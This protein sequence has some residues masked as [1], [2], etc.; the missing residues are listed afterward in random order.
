MTAALAATEAWWEPGTRHAYHTNTYGHL[1][2]EVVRRVSGESCRQRL[3]GAGGAARRRRPRRRPARRSATAAPRWSSTR[4]PSLAASTDFDASTATTDGDAQ[5]LQPAG[6]LLHGRRQHGRVARRRGA[7][8]ERAR[9][10]A[11]AWRA[12]TPRCSNRAAALRR[13][14]GRGDGAAVRGLLPDPPRGGD[15]RARFKPTVPRRPFGPNPRSFGHFGTGGA[16]G[17]ADPDGGVAFG[18]VMNDVIPRWQSTRNR[19]LIDAVFGRS[20]PVPPFEE[21]VAEGAARPGRGLGLLLV[22]GPGHR[23]AAAVGLRP[24]AWG[25]A[26]PAPPR[27]STSRRAAARSSP[28]GAQP[29]ALLVATE[30]WPPNVAVARGRCAPLGAHVVAVAD[31]PDV[32]VRCRVVRP[33]GQPPPRRR[34]VGARSPG[35][36]GPAGPIC[37]SRS[38]R[39]P[40][41][42]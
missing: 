36:C 21:L 22:R 33:G 25:S 41:A 40:T 35:S 20:E 16:V 30:S 39:G 6:L 38:A 7:V 34:A 10:G 3:A 28:P 12:C 26:W 19:A 5:L 17:F 1:I 2:G 11:R 9:H 15:V 37:P 14:A 29:P 32:A 8:D 27:P 4:R 42:S 13:P 18:Y 31:A 23:G 24:A